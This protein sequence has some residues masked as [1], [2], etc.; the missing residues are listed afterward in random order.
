MSAKKCKYKHFR[1]VEK[2]IYQT[3]EEQVPNRLLFLTMGVPWISHEFI[4]PLIMIFC[5]AFIITNLVAFIYSHVVYLQ[6]FLTSTFLTSTLFTL[7][8]YDVDNNG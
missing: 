6:Y 3:F 4:L 1:Q 8:I 7:T 2:G 5:I